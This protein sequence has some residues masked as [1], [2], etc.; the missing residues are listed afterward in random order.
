M[1]AEDFF[2]KID[3]ALLRKQKNDLARA[4]E[5]IDCVG[6]RDSINGI[7]NFLDSTQDFAVDE[8]KY[9]EMIVFGSTSENTAFNDA[10]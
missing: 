2:E 8:L 6:I 9:N 1:N 7:L 4:I 3:Y 10:G 5:K